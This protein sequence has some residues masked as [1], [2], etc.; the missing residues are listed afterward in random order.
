MAQTLTIEVPDEIDMALDR[1]GRTTRRDR[2]AMIADAISDF[3]RR[4]A[5]VIEGIDR[6][7]DDMR[8]GRVVPHDD[9][10][11]RVRR[12]IAGASNRGTPNG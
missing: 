12:A 9:A 11:R 6:G 5:A 2:P 10:M 3:V 8:T 4:E 7:L 1:I